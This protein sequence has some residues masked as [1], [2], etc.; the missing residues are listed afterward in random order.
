MLAAIVACSDAEPESPDD[1]ADGAGGMG[2]TSPGGGASGVGGGGGG[3]GV[4]AQVAATLRIIDPSSGEGFAGVSVQ[5]RVDPAVEVTDD[6]GRATVSVNVGRG[7]RVQLD[8]M[9]ARRH[10]VFGVATADPFE[11]ITFM[12]PD[13]VTTAVFGALGLTDDGGRGILVVGLDLPSLA[14]A[15]GATASIDAAADAP[16]IFVNGMPAAGSELVPGA[17]GFVTFPNVAPGMVTITTTF[18]DGACRVFPAET[19]A[20]QVEVIAGEVSVM[21]FTCR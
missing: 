14:P 11:Q 1:D 15:L 20:N 19:Q 9:D 6:A 7:Y 16:F 2:A 5:S 10:N 13:A 4:P 3:G 17:Q 21:A 12:S 8:A 18:P